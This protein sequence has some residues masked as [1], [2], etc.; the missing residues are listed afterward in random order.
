M[1]ILACIYHANISQELGLSTSVPL[2]Q[3]C[4]VDAATCAPWKANSKAARCHG[5]IVCDYLFRRSDVLQRRY[6]IVICVGHEA[7]RS[8]RPLT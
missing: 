4:L 7:Y 5:T 2:L 6:S 1:G 8:P 3:V